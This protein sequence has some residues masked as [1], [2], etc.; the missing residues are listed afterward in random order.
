MQTGSIVPLRLVGGG[1]RVRPAERP[2]RAC[3]A[4]PTRTSDPGD[5][6]ASSGDSPRRALVRLDE[7]L[8]IRERDGLRAAVY[9]QLA[10]DALDVRADRRGADVQRRAMSPWFRPLA[11]RRRTSLSRA[12]SSANVSGRRPLPLRVSPL[13][14]QS[15]Q[16]RGQLVR[17]DRLDDVVVGADEQ[18][19]DAIRR[20]HALAADEDDRKVLSVLSRN[21]RQIS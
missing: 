21:S 19:D 5:A 13:R 1:T 16:P 7:P 14:D 17:I 2:S 8:A 18:A 10:E 15:S 12:V 4:C 6:L 11:S 9:V 3:A 20:L